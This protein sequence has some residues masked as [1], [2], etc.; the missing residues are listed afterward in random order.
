V[1]VSSAG[2]TRTPLRGR[3]Q[4]LPAI[5][6]L[7]ILAVLFL[8]EARNASGL[9]VA[10][11]AAG[12]IAYAALCVLHLEGAFLLLCVTTPFSLEMALGANKLQIPTEPM[13]FVALTTWGFRFL[14]R[15]TRRIA[16][17]LFVG[18]LLAGL[19]TCLLSLVDAVHR[20]NG[21]KAT[22]NAAWYALFG[23]FLLNNM[24]S[25]RRQRALALFFLVPGLVVTVVS[26]TRVALG[27]Y[28]P[29]DGLWRFKPFFTEHGS[30]AA[31]LS[32]LM[33]LLLALA[34]ELRGGL[35]PYLWVGA[36]LVMLQIILSL[37]RGAWLG[38]PVLALFLGALY[39]RRLLHPVGIA[40]V[41]G[42]LGLL[43]LVLV[44]TG[45][46]DRLQ[47]YT[48]T[49]SDVAYTSNL[50][51]VN[52]WGAGWRMFQSDLL[53]GV[54]FGTYPDLYM[55]YRSL[56][57]GTDQSHIRMGIHSEYFKIPV[58][59]GI[60]GTAV[61]TLV[62]LAVVRLAVDAIRRAQTPFLR[63]M[64]V[65]LAGGLLTYMVHGWVNNYLVFDKVAIPVWTA[66]G[67]LGA[68]RG[69]NA[70]LARRAAP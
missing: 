36:F 58:E 28:N 33:A 53:T 62:L 37:T 22:V 56:P 42:T 14:A 48:E 4:W 10:A 29:A 32:F 61:A 5:F 40:L 52:R 47:E 64:A 3:A 35:R 25:E 51:R 59:T 55:D 1:P 12:I 20:V 2:W 50:E 69:L 6:L 30:F 24:Q 26:L 43:V 7:P 44:Q 65:G 11:L 27:D 70:R 68:L 49:T 46:F 8:L 16:E 34:L 41:A 60:L 21:M 63:A 67:G 13:L 15:G 31:Y 19:G 23:L 18:L 38:M 9:P 17:P 66:V 57:L 39:W 45:V 54:G